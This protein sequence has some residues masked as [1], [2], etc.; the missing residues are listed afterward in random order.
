MMAGWEID[1]NVITEGERKDDVTS[2][3]RMGGGSDVIERGCCVPVRE[4][5]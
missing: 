1:S 4:V 3:P 5:V 2:A